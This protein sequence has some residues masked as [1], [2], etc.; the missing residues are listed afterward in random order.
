LKTVALNSSLERIDEKAFK[1]CTGLQEIVI[2]DSVTVIEWAEQIEELL[3]EDTVRIVIRKDPAEG[4]DFREIRI[5]APDGVLPELYKK[6][7]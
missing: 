1:E 3:P 6:A 7:Q 5:T 2:P 4:A